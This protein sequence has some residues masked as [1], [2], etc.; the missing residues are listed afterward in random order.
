MVNL[1]YF[2]IKTDNKTIG[3]IN[4]FQ[5]GMNLFSAEIIINKPIEFHNKN[6]SRNKRL[7]SFNL[8]VPNKK[9][10]NMSKEQLTILIKV[11]LGQH[12]INNFIIEERK[13]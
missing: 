4:E 3:Y 8:I 7:S 12:N 6:Y 2:E 11:Y 5:K 1:K 13:I 10:D 9:F